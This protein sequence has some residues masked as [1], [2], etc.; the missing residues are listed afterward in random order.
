MQPGNQGASGVRGSAQ[1]SLI[2]ATIGFFIGFGAVSLF[3]PTAHSF[4]E[5]MRLSPEQVGLLVAVPM[6][7][8]SLLRIP[9]GAWVDLNGGKRPFLILLLASVV[10]I[11]GLYWMLL[12]LYPA[13]LG[14]GS[15]PMPPG[16][17]I[18][19]ENREKPAVS[20]SATQCG[21]W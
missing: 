17:R 14:A 11:G 19:D 4:I 12:T 3:G 18:S 21:A 8:G 10:G 20:P 5:V 9:F 13:H 6:L 15:Y 1:R 2:G 16:T 7:T